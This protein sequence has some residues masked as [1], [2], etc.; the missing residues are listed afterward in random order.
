VTAETAT[1]SN[2]TDNIGCSAKKRRALRRGAADEGWSDDEQ[3][4]GQSVQ[5]VQQGRFYHKRRHGDTAKCKMRLG[6][7]VC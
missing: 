4:L 6:Q 5:Q 2:S 3:W 1:Q 7:C